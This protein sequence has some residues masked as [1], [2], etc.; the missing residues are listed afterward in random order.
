MDDSTAQRVFD[1]L[2]KIDTKI[3]AYRDEIVD[4]KDGV[5]DKMDKVLGELVKIRT[6]QSVSSNRMS[7]IEE[8]VEKIESIPVI[9][10]SINK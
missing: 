3:E 6:E 1:Y 9:A 5:H 4:F 2:S 10:H 7:D 8:R